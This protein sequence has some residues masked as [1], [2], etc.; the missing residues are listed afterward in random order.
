MVNPAT[1]ATPKLHQVL[2]AH[3]LNDDRTRF[4]VWAPSHEHVWVELVEPGRRIEMDRLEHG[5]HFAEI[6]GV[7]SGCLYRYVLGETGTDSS[8]AGRPDPASRY[9]PQGV[10]GPSMV[11]AKDHHWNDA[12]W[13]GVRREDLVIYELHLGAFTQEG[14]FLSAIDRL[15]E[16]VELGMTAI[17]LM[18][19]ADSAGGWNWGYD[20]VNLFAPNRN[21]G[22]P[23]DL[24]RLVDA[25]HNKGLAV[26]LDVVYNHLGPEGNYLGEY[27]SYLSEHH[28][29]VWGAAPNFDDPRFG[30]E[31]RR[32]FIANAIHWLDE[33]HLDGLRIDA[34]HCMRDDSETHIV[35]ELSQ[36]VRDWSSE[37]GRPAML[38][39]ESN[40][41]DPNMLAPASQDGMGFDAEWCDD[42]LHSVFAVARPGEQL[43]HRPYRSGTDLEQTLRFG[44]VYEG[45]LRDQR[46][47]ATPQESV[48]RAGLVYSIQHHDFIGN[49][50]LGKRL[51]QVTSR[52]FQRASAALMLLSPA[53]PM[54]FMGEEF[55]CEHPF[56]FFVDFSDEPLRQAVVA[57]RQ[58]EYPQHD[59]SGGAMPIEPEAFYSSKIGACED[60]DLRMRDW[61]RQLILQRKNWIRSGLLQDKNLTVLTDV[62]KGCYCLR[63]ER[64]SL[65][66]TVAVQLSSTS[67]DERIVR[68]GSAFPDDR[69]GELLLDSRS[70]PTASDALHSNHAK[71]FVLES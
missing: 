27:D 49:H 46:G 18:P 36:C 20:G 70:E 59:W 6:D 14:T 55:A 10:H 39:A 8:Q 12:D 57:G 5:F 47:R 42:F 22:T 30:R 19:I 16:L 37:T 29:T 4:C 66:G 11:V 41:Y 54:M 48:D 67:E 51:H 1:V 34:I 45:T 68:L 9:Q 56:H 60:G 21:Y 28:T 69:F 50:P 15:D 23:R 40:V 13:T 3:V 58:R 2:G 38:I 26:F 61:Y 62:K 65:I 53:I 63:Y 25:A 44:Y 71:V 24:C 35:S 32:F 33:Y 43:C 7:T 64:G 52:D 17:E 31:L